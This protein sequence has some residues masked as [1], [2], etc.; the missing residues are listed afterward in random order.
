MIFLY[1][2]RDQYYSAGIGIFKVRKLAAYHDH[3]E[4]VQNGIIILEMGLNN[5]TK[6][7]LYCLLLRLVFYI[8]SKQQIILHWKILYFIK[9]FLLSFKNKIVDQPEY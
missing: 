2:E 5:Q 8:K 7:I 1:L 3:C 6:N 9:E 4:I